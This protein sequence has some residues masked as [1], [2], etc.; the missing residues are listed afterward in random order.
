MDIPP[1]ST[2]RAHR[3]IILAGGAMHAAP[4]ADPDGAIVIAADSGYDH[5]RAMGLMVD[6]LVGD[7]D[8]ISAEG[9]EH[10]ATHDV[11]IER[12][13]ASKDETDLELALA[14]AR[15]L[16]ATTV[17]VHGGEDGR[18]AHLLGI[19]LGLTHARIDDLDVAWHT[20]TGVIAVATPSRTVHVSGTVG[21]IVSLI[22]SGSVAGVT[23][24]GLRWH[25]ADD[26]LEA[27]STRGL[28][29]EMGA[30]LASVSVR[31]GRLLV[32]AE[33]EST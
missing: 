23:T 31:A 9:L 13:D 11:T 12:H 6:V 24:E 3:A 17:A 30:T 28:S 5:A 22:P 8:S 15:R 21:D 14:V 26:A 4:P 10:A 16:G 25:L 32:I 33:R 2:T 1:T 27:G 20:R 18:I 19:A 7:M 29:N